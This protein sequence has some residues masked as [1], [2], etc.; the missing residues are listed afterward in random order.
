[1]WS[2]TQAS[3]PMIR[4]C[5]VITGVYIPVT[6]YICHFELSSVYVSAIKGEN[7]TSGCQHSV[8]K[9]QCSLPHGMQN[10]KVQLITSN[11]ATLSKIN[12]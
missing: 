12:I 9:E 1:M 7:T 5:T 10:S 3:I 2:V 4:Q 8:I 6:V 11:S